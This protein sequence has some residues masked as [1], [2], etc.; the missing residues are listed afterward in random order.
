MQREEQ[1]GVKDDS[2][3]GQAAD[4]GVIHWNMTS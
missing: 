4:D 3:T 1:G 2:L